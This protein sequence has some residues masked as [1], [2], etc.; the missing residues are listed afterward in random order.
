M[1]KLLRHTEH[2]YIYLNEREFE[3]KKVGK[4]CKI[5]DNTIVV[6]VNVREMINI[7]TPTTA[8]VLPQASSANN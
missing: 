8:A 4:I 3:G 6:C 5:K 1:T 2:I 7:I